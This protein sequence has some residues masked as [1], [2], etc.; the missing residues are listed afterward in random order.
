VDS[1]CV[2]DLCAAIAKSQL[3]GYHAFESSLHFLLIALH[4]SRWMRRCCELE[5]AP[6]I[7]SLT[8]EHGTLLNSLSPARCDMLASRY[9]IRPQHF[10]SFKPGSRAKVTLHSLLRARRPVPGSYTDKMGV[11]W[12]V[13]LYDIDTT[14]SFYSQKKI[15]RTYR[16]DRL[17]FHESLRIQSQREPPHSPR[18]LLMQNLTTKA[19]PWCTWNGLRRATMSFK[20]LRYVQVVMDVSG[21]IFLART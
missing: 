8:Q 14:H 18:N 9:C 12:K 16:P 21:F 7:Y 6:C 1:F 15:T 20:T 2:F 10:F 3:G 19:R 11:L 4:G 5:F 17:G 13:A